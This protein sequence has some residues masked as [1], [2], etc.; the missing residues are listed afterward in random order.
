MNWYDG[1]DIM[2]K[3]LLVEPGKTYYLHYT[4]RHPKAARWELIDVE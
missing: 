1:L 3:N 4:L 2:P